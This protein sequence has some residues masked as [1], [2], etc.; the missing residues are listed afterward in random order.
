VFCLIWGIA[1][2]LSL[3]RSSYIRNSYLRKRE[4]QF[5]PII[6]LLTWFFSIIIIAG[7]LYGLPAYY[8]IIP[9]IFFVISVFPQIKVKKIPKIRQLNYQIHFSILL[10]LLIL[11]SSIMFLF[12][13]KPQ[14]EESQGL[15]VMTFNLHYGIDSDGRYYVENMAKIMG[16][17][18][19][20]LIG[21][22]EVTRASLLNGG[23]DLYQQLVL[24]MKSYGFKYSTI[25]KTTPDNL[26]NAIFSKYPLISTESFNYPENV[27]FQRGFIKS[28]VVIGNIEYCIIVTHLTHEYTSDANKTRMSQVKYLLQ[29]LELESRPIII[30]G[31]FNVE[32][33]DIEIELISQAFN[34]SWVKSNQQTLGLTWPASNPEQRLDYIFCSPQ[35]NVTNVQVIN[36]LSSD[37]FPVIATI[38]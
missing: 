11:G 7:I 21:V 19:A 12:S 38:N 15:T 36:T 33:I 34:D 27:V 9:F 3:D 24:E 5:I 22:Q 32:P 17:S 23:G 20:H 30:L 14:N 1:F 28:I 2:L 13:P 31:D 26:H 29:K 4:S 16:Q 25:M 10:I 37:H 6:F 35:I 18:G 8:M